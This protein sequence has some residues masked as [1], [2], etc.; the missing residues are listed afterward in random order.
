M[1]AGILYTTDG[2]DAYRF[3]GEESVTVKVALMKNVDTGKVERVQDVSKFKRLVIDGRFKQEGKAKQIPLIPKERKPKRQ[4][5]DSQSQPEDLISTFHID[6]LNC[7][8]FLGTEEQHGETLKEATLTL[9]S[10]LGLANTFNEVKALAEGAPQSQG[11]K[12]LL[13]VLGE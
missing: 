13:A 6:G 10:K 12:E 7:I 4:T 9:F 11:R 5:P 3:A 1:E 8:A 2:K